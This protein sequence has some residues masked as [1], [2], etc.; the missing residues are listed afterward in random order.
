[1]DGFNFWLISLTLNQ[2]ICDPQSDIFNDIINDGLASVF[3]DEIF[4]FFGDGVEIVSGD[5]SDGFNVILQG[6]FGVGFSK[7]EMNRE[8]VLKLMF[9]EVGSDENGELMWSVLLDDVEFVQ[10][11]V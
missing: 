9:G 1:L 3:V 2:E 6:S 8:F 4:D 5:A 11:N 7:F 10:V